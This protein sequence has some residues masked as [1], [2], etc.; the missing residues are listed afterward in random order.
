MSIKWKQRLLAMLPFGLRIVLG[1]VFIYACWHKIID[2]PAFARSIANYQI[3][4][5][6]LVNPAALLMP[7][8][9]LVCG[10][11]LITGLLVRGSA[12]ILSGLLVTFTAA[13]TLSLIR[14]L[15][16]HCGCFT[17]NSGAWTN[18]YLD[19]A[20]DVILLAIAVFIVI[21]P[22]KTKRIS[23][24]AYSQGKKE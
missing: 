6:A 13:L 14:G 5:R 16:I 1:C 20:L 15:D 7:W 22:G 2:P 24:G 3:L 11:S 21:H 10:V 8:L 23:I 19:I 12:L 17:A 9:E 18:L 4:P